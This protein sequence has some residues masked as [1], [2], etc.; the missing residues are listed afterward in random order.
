MIAIIRSS[1]PSGDHSGT[2]YLAVDCSCDCRAVES[3]TY[4]SVFESAIA[5]TGGRDA[6]CTKSRV[7]FR[8]AIAIP[9]P[10][11]VRV[12]MSES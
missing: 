2:R 12:R 5:W 8:T 1:I 7:T 10:G 6:R 3:S 11:V 9:R 4:T